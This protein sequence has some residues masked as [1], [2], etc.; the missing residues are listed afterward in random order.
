M[1]EFGIKKKLDRVEYLK[2]DISRYKNVANGTLDKLYIEFNKRKLNPE[3]IENNELKFE[4]LGF[5]FISRSEIA[6]N[7]N[8][9]RFDNGKLSTYVFNKEDKEELILEYEFDAVGNINNM[10]SKNEFSQ[11]YYADFFIGLINYTVDN[12][13]RFKI[14]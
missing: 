5:K 14:D 6:F 9:E 3:Q 10:L 11:Y 1:N 2:E 13:L 8:T 4:Y 12:N 7:P